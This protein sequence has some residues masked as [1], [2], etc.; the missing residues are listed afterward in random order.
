MTGFSSHW[1]SLREPYDARARNPV[2][3]DLVVSSFGHRSPINI[4]DLGAGGGAALRA[5]APHFPVE[6]HWRLFDN[7]PDLLANAR[8]MRSAKIHVE[9]V[10]IDLS[11]ELDIALEGQI[12]LVTCSAFLDLVSERWLEQFA[13]AVA[14]RGLPVYA[15]LTYDGRISICPTHPFD[16]MIIS[17]VNHHQRTDKGFGPAM[18]PPSAACAV[19]RFE[20][21]GY[22]VVRDRADWLLEPK[23]CDIQNEL[24]SEWA[25]AAGKIGYASEDIADW[26]NRRRTL[27]AACQSTIRVGH[28]DFRACQSG[29]RTPDRSKSNNTSS[30]S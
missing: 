2:I 30:S 22:S 9:A 27:V 28:T 3:L 6:Q 8:R 13:S 20:T 11:R 23:D 16:R 5:L 19:A 24:L 17:A 29:T 4:V 14:A 1:L 10:L 7:D 18:G 25:D 21:L 12:D 15:T 26:L